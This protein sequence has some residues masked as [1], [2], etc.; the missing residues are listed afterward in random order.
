[1]ATVETRVPDTV[2]TAIE[3]LVIPR[4]DMTMNSPNVSS[5]RCV[6]GHLLEPEQ[7]D[8]SGEIEGIQ[9]TA[10]SRINSHTY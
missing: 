6:D 9:K 5:G 3:T 1:M 2:L 8:F 7:R 10:L 4:V